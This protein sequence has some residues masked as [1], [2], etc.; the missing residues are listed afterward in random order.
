MG[1]EPL[2][3]GSQTQ[4]ATILFIFLLQN[5]LPPTIHVP[6]LFSYILWHVSSLPL[7][8]ELL[9]VELLLCDK[10]SSMQWDSM[11]VK[12]MGSLYLGSMVS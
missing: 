10:Y 6:T 12:S 3:V 11:M 8:S 5:L 2:L 7:A 4:T 1:R 9:P